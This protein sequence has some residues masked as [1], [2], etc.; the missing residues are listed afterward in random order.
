[1]DSNERKET[2]D[3]HRKAKG[4]VQIFPTVNVTNDRQLAMA[5]IPG[6]IT[7]CEEIAANPKTAYDY[8]GKANR[9]AEISNGTAML[10]MG[11]IGP[12]ASMPILEGKCLILKL[13]GDVNAIP[14]AINA[15]TSEEI[16]G[17]CKAI[18][19]S[20]GGINIEDISS[21]DTFYVVRELAETLD[22]PVFCD[23][24]Q[25]TAII[26]LSAVRNSLKL[27]GKPIEE[28]KIVVLGAGSAGI[29]SAELLLVAGAKDL[30]IL[31]I[32][33]ILGPSNTNMDP[34]QKDISERTNP[35]GLSGGLEEA[36]EGAD[37][38]VGLSRGGIVS[39]EHIMKM[40]EKPVVLA[41][42][43]PEPEI[44]SAEA[45]EGGAYIYAS[46]KMEDSNTMLNIHAFPGLIRG[47]LDVRAKKLTNSMFLA[48]SEALAN[49]VDKRYLSPERICP[50]F[51]GSETT[52]RIAEA[53]GQ[54]A[55]GDRVALLPVPEGKIYEE[56][57][58][59]LFGDLGHI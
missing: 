2:L 40:G 55:I 58:K 39:K 13:M 45:V 49:M 37:I 8:T 1:M 15:P 25:G 34:I 33:G 31:S 27:L 50:R 32:D 46:G 48:A 53:V 21:P 20:F 57:W 36:I 38:L 5:Y 18:A 26:I 35:R 9:I 22:I 54:A 24:Q 11:D 17:F 19:P 42:A 6:S 43:L 28:A 30:T 16:I 47:A 52:P 4:K 41:L 14:L 59:R 56:T 10:G 12:T 7:A 51:F 29:A 3:Y 44:S 23:D